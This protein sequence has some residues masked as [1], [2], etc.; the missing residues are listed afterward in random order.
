MVGCFLFGFFD[1]DW[2]EVYYLIKKI[3]VTDDY[4]LKWGD[5]DLEKIKK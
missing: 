4:E 2:E 1:F 3:P 5:I